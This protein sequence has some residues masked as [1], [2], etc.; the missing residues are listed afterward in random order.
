MCADES[1][2]STY[3]EYLIELKKN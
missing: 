3:D 1:I 2:E